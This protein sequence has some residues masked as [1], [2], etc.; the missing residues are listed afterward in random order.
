MVIKY[1]AL[2]VP[3]QSCKERIM[4]YIVSHLSVERKA[5]YF[6][7]RKSHLNLR[8]TIAVLEANIWHR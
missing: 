7:Q 8:G 4:I 6:R 1:K 3:M 5:I 2:L